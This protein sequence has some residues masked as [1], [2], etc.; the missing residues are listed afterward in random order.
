MV[1]GPLKLL[2]PAFWY[3]ALAKLGA[4]LLLV[5]AGVAVF[6]FIAIQSGSID[7]GIAGIVEEMLRSL[8]GI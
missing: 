8:L 4:R 2:N 5:L 7:V 6:A 1:G 3:L